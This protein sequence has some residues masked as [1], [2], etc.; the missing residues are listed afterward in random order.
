MFSIFKAKPKLTSFIQ[1][2]Q[3]DIHSHLL[4]GLDDGA[5]TPQDT[6]DLARKFVAAG[7]TH[8]IATPHVMNTVWENTA[9]GILER[10]EETRKLLVENQ[11]PL[12][13]N[14]AAEYLM[15][16]GFLELARTKQLLPLKENKV[17]VEMSY[18]NPPMNL[19]E[20]L[21]EMQLAGYVPVLA[22]P[23]R[24]GFYNNA[25]A[26]YEK[27]KNAGCLFQVNLLS[28]MGYYGSS[29]AKTA[30]TLL[31]MGLIDYVGTD[32]HHLNHAQGLEAR[33]VIRNNAAL[34]LALEKS[35]EFSF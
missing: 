22:H 13:I 24:Y 35:R 20:I 15:D 16:T 23:E 18:I 12:R 7:Y 6:L 28:A 8:C 30:D 14:A 27:L 10:L 21:F 1:P 19:F 29:A 34:E 9:S 33:S 4:F 26:E 31:G 5:K 11:V 17:L 32:M 25:I 3:T 2:G